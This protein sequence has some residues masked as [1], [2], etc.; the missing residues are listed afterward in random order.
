[1]V[2]YW[3]DPES[4]EVTAGQGKSVPVAAVLEGLA[5]INGMR[6]VIKMEMD[7][8]NFLEVILTGVRYKSV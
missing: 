7:F 6:E 8:A 5:S 3:S 1:M 2:Y 4:W